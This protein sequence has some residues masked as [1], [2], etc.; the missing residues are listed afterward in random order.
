MLEARHALAG[1]RSRP[2][3]PP[4]EGPDGKAPRGPTAKVGFDANLSHHAQVARGGKAKASSTSPTC[5]TAGLRR[6][7]RVLVGPPSFST[8]T[9]KS[10]SNPPAPRPRRGSLR[11]PFYRRDHWCAARLITSAGE[12]GG[13]TQC[14]PPWPRCWHE[15]MED[16]VAGRPILIARTPELTDAKCLP[17]TK[18]D[19]R[20][21]AAARVT[22]LH[23]NSLPH[24]S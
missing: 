14:E 12:Y 16:R 13:R 23:A 21:G 20:P 15:K 6:R 11:S 3:R 2:F 8:V 5:C 7:V 18:D 17:G 19:G 1:P 4:L 22:A 9:V 10:V 24:R